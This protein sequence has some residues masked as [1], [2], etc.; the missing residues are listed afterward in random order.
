MQVRLF[1][2]IVVSG[3]RSGSGTVTG[4]GNGIEGQIGLAEGEIPVITPVFKTPQPDG[5][6]KDEI[7]IEVQQMNSQDFYGTITPT[8]ARISIFEGVLGLA[9][10]DLAGVTVGFNR[11]RTITYELKQQRDID[12]LYRFE[13]FEF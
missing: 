3:S 1:S 6:F 13:F 4:R 5:P 2:E 12:Q 9:Q 11:G 8:E 10:D 7:V